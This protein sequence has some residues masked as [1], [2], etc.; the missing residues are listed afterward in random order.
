M[1]KSSQQFEAQSAALSSQPQPPKTEGKSRPSWTYCGMSRDSELDTDT[2]LALRPCDPRPS[3]LRASRSSFRRRSSSVSFSPKSKL[4]VI[5]RRDNYDRKQGQGSY[6]A[7]DVAK[8]KKE[9]SDEVIAFL[10][11]KYVPGT[12]HQH[13]RDMCLV[14]IE[15]Y[16]LSP[17]FKNQRARARALVRY[18]VLSEQARTQGCVGD[19]AA[20]IAEVSMQYSERSVAQAKLIG[21]FQFIQSNENNE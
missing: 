17:N 19:M 14:G 4:I 11:L 16:L 5:E 6:T 21:E 13:H 15:Q 9:A 18:A 1:L 20:R 8:F 7:K 2:S 3:I 12:S 10:H